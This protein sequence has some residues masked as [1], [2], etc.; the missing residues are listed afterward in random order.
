M[1]LVYREN[2]LLN[3]TVYH[4]P[5]RAFSILLLTENALYGT[6]RVL[7]RQFFESLVLAKYSEIDLSLAERWNRDGTLSISNDVFS[8]LVKKD[9]SELKNFWR[10][11]C[12]FT[13][14]TLYASQKIMFPQNMFENKREYYENIA[15]IFGNIEYNLDT[16][17]VLLTMSYHLI[18]G[19]LGKKARGWWFGYYCDPHGVYDREKELKSSFKNLKKEYLGTLVNEKIRKRISKIIFQSRQ[20]WK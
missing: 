5:F 13:H 17:F 4:L 14:P 7:I 6:A 10:E 11:T 2:S 19:H 18:I 3:N 8:K 20:C 15:E 16:L 1:N 12:K 9:I